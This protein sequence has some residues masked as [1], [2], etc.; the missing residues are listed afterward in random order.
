MSTG[1]SRGTKYSKLL[2]INSSNRSSGTNSDFTIDYGVNMSQ[3]AGVSIDSIQFWN[4]IYNIY[5][6][7]LTSNNV[8]RLTVTPPAGSPTTYILYWTPGYYSAVD[9]L[10]NFAAFALGT[11]G[12]TFNW[13]IGQYGN[14][15]TTSVPGGYA[16]T[17]SQAHV[18]DLQGKTQTEDPWNMLGFTYNNSGNIDLVNGTATYQP[19]MIHTSMAYLT[20]RILAPGNSFDE[21]GSVSNVLRPIA[22]NT[23]W[24]ELVMFE[25][26]DDP[27]CSIWYPRPRALNQIDIQLVDHEGFNID[28][29]QSELNIE[30]RIW[31]NNL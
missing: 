13:D 4:Q 1:A 24:K 18:S 5:N 2:R 21:K 29:G 23:G 25:C 17:V 7:S 26:K 30:L 28:L 10:T 14:K 16:V 6:T 3:V 19:Y 12:F 22:I 27:L 31:Y 8:F 11:Y 20:S 15:V 9:F